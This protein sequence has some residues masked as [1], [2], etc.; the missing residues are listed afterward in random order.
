MLRSVEM[1][2]FRAQVPNRDAA[3]ATRAIAGTR[4]SPTSCAGGESA[5]NPAAE[6]SSVTR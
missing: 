4:R 1:M 5:A 6:R 3:V 2:H